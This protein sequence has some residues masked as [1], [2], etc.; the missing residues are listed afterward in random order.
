MVSHKISHN[1][2]SL[3][4]LFSLWPCLNMYCMYNF[5]I[6]ATNH[7]AILSHSLAHSWL[8]GPISLGLQEFPNTI[9]KQCFE[10]STFKL[11][12]HLKFSNK[13]EM[14]NRNIYKFNQLKICTWMNTLLNSN[15]HG[16]FNT[17][18]LKHDSDTNFC[19][20][21]LA[22]F[23]QVQQQYKTCIIS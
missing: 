17:V 15:I 1:K 5:D 11:C 13:V 14:M 10:M 7:P 8:T 16:G 2:F 21:D 4:Y 3:F 18:I 6:S 22:N 9:L 20:P 12:M 23:S 19:Q